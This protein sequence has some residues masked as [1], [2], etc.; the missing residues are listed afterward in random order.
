VDHPGHVADGLAGTERPRCD[1]DQ[2]CRERQ[3][4]SYFFTVYLLTFSLLD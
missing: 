1:G 4:E 3:S 2:P